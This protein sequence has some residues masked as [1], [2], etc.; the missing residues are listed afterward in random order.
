MV[1]G[2]AHLQVA[3]ASQPAGQL[4]QLRRGGRFS[5]RAQVAGGLVEGWHRLRHHLCVG[6]MPRSLLHLR[7][8]GAQAPVHPAEAG[9]R[10]ARLDADGEQR[11]GEANAVAVVL[12]QPALLGLVEQHHGAGAQGA[13]QQV[14]GG[15]GQ[16]GHGQQQLLEV[17]VE[18]RQASLHDLLQTRR[19]HQRGRR[20]AVH[21]Q[22]ARQLQRVEEV[23][24]GRLVHALERAQGQ[25]PV[26]AL[27]HHVP[28]RA[29]VQRREAPDV[30]PLGVA[31]PQLAGRSCAGA[32]RVPRGHQP[33]GPGQPARAELQHA[34]AGAIEPLEAVDRDDH[35]L[36]QRQRLEH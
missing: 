5:P 36:P 15:L 10:G 26:G 23:A 3:R 4:E 18:T 34:P 7:H 14:G 19:E 22:L 1:L 12:H 32:V 16:G 20:R 31:K 25:R 11:V 24:A 9:Q 6:Q 17:G 28:Q 8:H 35:G 27:A 13:R 21:G 2:G 33:D 30:H 29:R